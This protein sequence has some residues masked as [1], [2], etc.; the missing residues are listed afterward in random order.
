MKLM[1]RKGQS[2]SEVAIT[3]CDLTLFYGGDTMRQ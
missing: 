3:P 1:G 2:K